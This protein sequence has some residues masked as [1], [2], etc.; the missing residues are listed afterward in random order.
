MTQNS[1]LRKQAL[2]TLEGNWG[3]AAGAAFVYFGLGMIA[4]T[5][6]W[7]IPV[8]LLLPMMFSLTV[9]FLDLSRG[10]KA[11]AAALFAR[12]KEGR[13]WWT[14]L[15]KNIYVILWTLLLIV[16]GIIKQYSYAMTEFLMRDDP[17]LT[18]NAAIE[19]SMQMMKGNKMRLFLLDLSFIGW[20]LLAL[21]TLGLGFILL[22]PYMN[23]ARAKFYEDL[24][25]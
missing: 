14:M 17:Q 9:M 7:G 22:I 23:T 24:R 12:Y 15:L 8:L 3:T 2:Q 4:G 13:V 21:L 10:G 11:N 18:G 25:S 6:L 20:Y 19:R 5:V 1:Q 16:P